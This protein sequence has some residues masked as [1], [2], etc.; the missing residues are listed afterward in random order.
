MNGVL[1]ET[2]NK[3]QKTIKTNIAGTIAKIRR[4]RGMRLKNDAPNTNSPVDSSISQAG[5][6]KKNNATQPEN[7]RGIA[8]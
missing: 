3:Q 5:I 7:D 2:D 8:G 1:Y 6:P 4:T